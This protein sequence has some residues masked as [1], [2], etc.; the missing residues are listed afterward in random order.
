PEAA[1]AARPN[2]RPACIIGLNIDR[3]LRRQRI[4]R[5]L[6]QRLEAGM[7]NEVHA[8]LD[9]GIDPDD[10]IY[11]GLEYKF[12]TL[13]LLGRLSLN[14]MTSQ[15]ETAIH[16]FAKRQ[17][18]WFRGMERRGHKIHWLEF[19]DPDFLEKALTIIG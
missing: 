15:L 16:Q 3:D 4:T 2:P 8:L 1:E 19:N 9:S 10:L 14:E 6:H 7:V 18:T 11:Y 13:H 12:L 17:M 5:R